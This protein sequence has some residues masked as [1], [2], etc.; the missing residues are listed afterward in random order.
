M[1]WKR[2]Q[3]VLDLGGR[4]LTPECAA[5]T[6][7]LALAKKLQPN[8]SAAFPSSGDYPNYRYESLGEMFSS[9]MFYRLRDGQSRYVPIVYHDEPDIAVA[10]R[11]GLP[12]V[13]EPAL[14][15]SAAVGK[16]HRGRPNSAFA[17]AELTDFLNPLLR[18]TIDSHAADDG[19]VVGRAILRLVTLSSTLLFGPAVSYVAFDVPGSQEYLGTIASQVNA[20]NDLSRIANT[21]CAYGTLHSVRPTGWSAAH[22][23][24]A[25]PVGVDRK[26]EHRP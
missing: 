8:A 4:T 25:S 12:P 1:L 11:T 22:R 7:A 24:A 26:K 17:E 14:G 2:D 21:P 23:P 18:W 3:V 6:A 13:F 19:L 15:D 9:E 10:L 20:L 16:R 5:A